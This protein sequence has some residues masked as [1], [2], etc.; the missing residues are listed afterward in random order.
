MSAN[1]GQVQIRRIDTGAEVAACFPLMQQ[2]R[3]H[4]ADADEF[5]A[6]WRRQADVG[7]R[8]A[9][10]WDDG[11]LMALAGYRLQDNLVHGLHFYVDDLVTDAQ[12]RS[13]GY[14]HALMDWLKAEAR[15]L[16]CHKLVLDTPLTNVLGHRFY[17][18]NG[19]LAAALRF[20]VVLDQ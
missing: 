19:L 17:Y 5:V 4:L 2:L 9:G 8:L 11:R 20:N 10:L 1:V 15:E 3:P 6:R 12:A 16:S 13:G 14:G 18:R 7:Y